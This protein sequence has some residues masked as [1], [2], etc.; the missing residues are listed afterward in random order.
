MITVKGISKFFGELKAL[1][2]VSFEVEDGET[3]AIIGPSGC[4][5]STLLLIMAGLLKP[6]EGEVLVDDRAVN[7]PLKN[8]AL[9]LQDFGL[10]PWKTVYDNVALGLKIRGFSRRAERERVTALLEKFGL[11]GF[12]KSYPKQLSGGMKQRVAIARAIAIEPQ[13]LLMDEP[14]SSLDALSRE[15]MQNFL[16]NLWKETKTTMVLVTHSIE[17]AVFLGRKIV[18]LTERPGR[19]KAVVDNREAGDESYRYEEVFFERCKLLRQTIRA[20]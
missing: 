6:S 14:L 15:E 7:S 19:V 18:V 8:A 20:T 9:I 16:L 11:K 5:K 3:C 10:F 12:E 17:E 1:D 2:G 13:I 4:G